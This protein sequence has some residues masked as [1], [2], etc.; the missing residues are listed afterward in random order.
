MKAEPITVQLNEND[1]EYTFTMKGYSTLAGVSAK[2]KYNL[3]D[4]GKVDI[5]DLVRLKKESSKENPQFGATDLA[6]L[7]IYLLS[8]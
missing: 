2:Y 3:I 6:K 4:D 5:L 1:M 8:N 7:R